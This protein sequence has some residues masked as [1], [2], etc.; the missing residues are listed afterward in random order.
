MSKAEDIFKI[1]DDLSDRSKAINK[2]MIDRIEEASTQIAKAWSGS[3]LGYHS[4]VYYEN[5]DPTPPGARFSSEWGFGD[6]F[7]NETVGSWGEYD[8]DWV[9]SQ[10]EE[11]AGKPDTEQLTAEARETVEYFEDAKEEILSALTR[12]RSEFANDN[13]LQTLEEKISKEKVLG[14]SDFARFFQGKGKFF[15]RDSVAAGQGI[16]TPPHIHMLALIGTWRQPF[17]LCKSLAKHA[18]R[19][20]SHFQSLEKKEKTISR[21]GTHVF[22]GH[23]RSSAWKE[24]RDFVRERLRLPCDEFN[25]VPVAGMTTISRLLQMLDDAEIAFLI[26]T[27]EDEQ[28]DGKQH[29]RM[30]V[31]HEAGL[32]QGRLGF[33]RA[34]ILLEEDCEEFSNVHG[35]GQIRFPKGKISDTFEEI[36]RVLERE[37]LIDGP[38][39][40]S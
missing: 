2:S 25:R 26:L 11:R 28:A 40:E 21:Q 23:G 4:R 29:A 13:F 12:W 31:I 15:T 1:A 33:E 5:L 7:S 27:A 16:Q 8:F 24:L 32:F 18:R 10:I 17:I 3:W 6:Q 9:I 36:R 39:Q 37:G 22:L 34:I 14:H 38:E 30:N 19:G 35:L 20:A